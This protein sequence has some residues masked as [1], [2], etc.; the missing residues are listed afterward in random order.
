M[1]FQYD[2]TV[3]K[4]RNALKSLALEGKELETADK[5]EPFVMTV[6]ATGLDFRIS[7]NNVRRETWESI[8]RILGRYNETKELAPGKYKD[9]SRNASYVLSLLRAVLGP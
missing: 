3:T 4:F 5:K 2:I 1:P 7:N 8:G 9:V 6:C